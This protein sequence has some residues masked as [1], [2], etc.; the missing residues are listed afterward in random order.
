MEYIFNVFE[1]S[2]VS[3][4]EKLPLWKSIATIKSPK[5]KKMNAIGIVRK[6]KIAIE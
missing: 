6:I 1:V 3:K 5:K 4:D 2:N